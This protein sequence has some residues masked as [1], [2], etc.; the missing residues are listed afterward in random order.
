[1]DLL[2]SGRVALLLRSDHLLPGSLALYLLLLAQR[3]SLTLWLLHL[4]PHT[5]ALGLNWNAGLRC[6]LLLDLLPPQILHL[7]PRV[8][9][10]ARCLPG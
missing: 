10:P 1:M 8:A 5:F 9:T 7:L 6:S 4:L 2:L 3:F